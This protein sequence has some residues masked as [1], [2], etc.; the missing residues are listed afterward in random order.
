M[1]DHIAWSYA[2]LARADAALRDRFTKY[3]PVHHMIR[4]RLFK[5]LKNGTMAMRSLYDDER[6]KMTVPNACYYCGSMDNP[7][8]D[9][10][11]PRVKGGAD[12]ADN[13]I[14]ACRSC[15]SSKHGRDML[16][17]MNGRNAFPS[18][19]LLRRYLKLVARYCDEHEL[20]LM[21]VPGGLRRDLPFDL[22]LVPHSFP[23]LSELTLWVQLSGGQEYWWRSTS[24]VC[25][26]ASRCLNASAN[27]ASRLATGLATT[28]W[29][30]FIRFSPGNLQ[31]FQH[32]KKY[33]RVAA[34]YP[35]TIPMRYAAFVFRYAK[36]I[37]ASKRPET[38]SYFWVPKPIPKPHVDP[39]E[40]EWEVLAFYDSDYGERVSQDAIWTEVLEFLS[41]WWHK[42]FD[43]VSCLQQTYAALPRGRVVRKHNGWGVA[44]GADAPEPG[45]IE[46]CKLFNIPRSEYVSYVDDDQAQ[47]VEHTNAFNGVFGL[48]I[49]APG[50]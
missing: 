47:V 5:G 34:L 25:S 43:D 9:H 16:D 37:A 3:Q 36:R 1:N 12:D 8:I 22:S 50:A 44:H 29:L 2:N 48:H 21:T 32:S 10:L 33:Q 4:A 24:S 28:R 40:W 46:I 31:M 41:I 13:L 20:L 39:S 27:P 26:V 23:P 30:T 35:D 11:I 38:G 6:I 19:L 49:P 15:N 17:W 42:D 45:E 14:R 18:V 7:S